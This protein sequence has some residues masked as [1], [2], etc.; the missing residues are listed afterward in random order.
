MLSLRLKS[1]TEIVERFRSRLDRLGDNR[2]CVL[3]Q[4][5]YIFALLWS[6]RYREAEKAQSNLS[7]MAARLQ[8]ARS[9][10]Y[11]LV[12]DIVVST[13]IAPKPVEIFE[14]LSREAITAASSVED[15]YL[16]CSVRWAVGWEE[17][18]RGRMAKA[19]E[20][21]EELMAVGRR[22]N[23]PRSI[24]NGMA[25]QTWIALGSDDYAAALNFADTS[26][27]V[28]LTPLDRLV[29]NN[30]RIVALV[31]LRRP[32]AVR[33]LRDYMDQCT[34]NDWR[35]ALAYAEGILGR[36]SGFARRD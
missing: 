18:Y 31:L 7:A 1:T 36:G 13:A 9:R 8:D 15:A 26:I 28:A 25:L 22:M 30:A 19:H 6:G 17:F 12:S 33:M 2:K 11:A 35:L 3:V 24:G 32:E 5:H 29:A 20:A 16:Q 21:A 23:D 27:N 4:H 14:A 34:A 10:A